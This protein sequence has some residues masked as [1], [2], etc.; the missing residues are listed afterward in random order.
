VAATSRVLTSATN[1]PRVILA[2]RRMAI[3]KPGISLAT[4]I[5][6]FFASPRGNL[7]AAVRVTGAEGRMAGWGHLP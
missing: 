4:R 3:S 6:A 5:S 1:P 7:L 2:G